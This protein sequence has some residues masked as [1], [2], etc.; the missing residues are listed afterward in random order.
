MPS[1]NRALFIRCAL[2]LALP[3]LAG[4]ATSKAIAAP[5]CVLTAFDS[6]IDFGAIHPPPGNREKSFKPAPMQ[7]T[8][9]AI[10]PEAAQ[11]NVVFQGRAKS[12][13]QLQFGNNASY[14][15]RVMSARLDGET[16][17][18]AHLQAAGA[19]P[20][21]APSGDL[22]LLPSDLFAPVS[23]QQLLSG[24]HLDFTLEIA[25]VIPVDTMHLNQQVNLDATGQLQLI[26]R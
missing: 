1:M 12:A 19:P 24:R 18:M 10:C 20:Q 17:Q 22:T 21:G 13:D 8:F 3:A 2:S 25:P 14:T 16:V 23:G 15:V 7:R 11:M 5:E 6:V 9:S 26:V 4:L